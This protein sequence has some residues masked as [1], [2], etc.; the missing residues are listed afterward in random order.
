ML[1]AIYNT[2]TITR[3]T[4][5][6]VGNIFSNMDMK[7]YIQIR[8]TNR[9]AFKRGWTEGKGGMQAIACRY[10]ACLS[11]L[12][13]LSAKGTNKAFVFTD[14]IGSHSQPITIRDFVGQTGPQAS[15]LYGTGDD[16]KAAFNGVGAGMMI[17]DAGCAIANGIYHK[18]FGTGPDIFECQ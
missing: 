5:V 10:H 8:R 11:H 3:Q 2:Q 13:V 6:L 16:I 9:A 17:D 12:I 15:L 1:Q 4:I 7:A 18:Y 14:S